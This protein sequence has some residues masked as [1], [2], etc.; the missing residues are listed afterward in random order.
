M[1]RPETLS[2]PEGDVAAGP[3]PELSL[4]VT[5]FQ[6]GATLE[7]LHRRLTAALEPLGRPYEVIYVDDGSTDGT[8]AALERIHAGDDRVRAVRLKRNVGS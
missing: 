4:V 6:E 8:F 1:A 7:E 3:G 2:A 5:L